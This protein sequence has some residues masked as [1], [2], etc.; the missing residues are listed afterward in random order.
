MRLLSLVAV[1]VAGFPML[2]FLKVVQAPGDVGPVVLL[3][4][5][6][7]LVVGP[8]LAMI[9]A[10]GRPTEQLPL[11]RLAITA[12]AMAPAPALSLALGAV[13]LSLVG[14]SLGDRLTSFAVTVLQVG[15][16]GMVGAT[17]VLTALALS[18]G[19]RRRTH[20]GLG[21]CVVAVLILMFYIEYAVWV[22]LSV[23]PE[24][25]RRVSKPSFR[26]SQW[27]CMLLLFKPVRLLR[28][29]SDSHRVMPVALACPFAGE[30]LAHPELNRGCYIVAPLHESFLEEYVIFG[31]S[32]GDLR[33][34]AYCAAEHGKGESERAD[35][36]L[37]GK[38][39]M[40]SVIE[41]KAWEAAVW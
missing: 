28:G 18:T 21:L 14:P 29:V 11:S 32:S 9:S 25:E 7:C 33:P 13:V 31:L 26:V 5:L 41:L 3:V 22:Y 10:L 15:A 2:L 20:R 19:V 8:V 24:V 12:A 34:C 6:A 17:A 39:G 30:H 37:A 38:T 35:V 4:M 27:Q 40:M 1:V 23:R 36:D 16:R